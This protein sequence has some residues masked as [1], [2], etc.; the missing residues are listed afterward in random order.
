MNFKL[1]AWYT[2]LPQFIPLTHYSDFLYLLLNK[3]S[4][5]KPLGPHGLLF[6]NIFELLPYLEYV[7]HL[8]MSKTALWVKL[9]PVSPLCFMST[10]TGT[11]WMLSNCLPWWF[12]I[13]NLWTLCTSW[14]PESCISL[15]LYSPHIIQ[16]KD[17]PHINTSWINNCMKRKLHDPIFIYK[18]CLWYIY[19]KIDW[20]W[21]QLAS[22]SYVKVDIFHFSIIV[23]VST[24][25]LLNVRIPWRQ[26]T[27]RYIFTDSLVPRICKCFLKCKEERRYSGLKSNNT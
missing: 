10:Y 22:K 17:R 8:M 14:E 16:A 26:T 6:W 12:T 18:A 11:V 3:R 20:K 25:S 19:R 2:P 27:P 21:F 15:S 1:L 9:S 5:S 7:S 24:F 4:N 23:S 13:I